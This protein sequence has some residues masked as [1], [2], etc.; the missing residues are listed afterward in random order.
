M[1]TQKYQGRHRP[2]T[3]SAP[4]ET[5]I[6]PPAA[7]IAE[8]ARPVQP[9]QPAHGRHRA[10]AG[11]TVPRLAGT[12]L[13]LPTAAAAAL[14][15][16]TTG[17]HLGSTSGELSRSSVQAQTAASLTDQRTQDLQASALAA[18]ARDTQ[19]ADRDLQRA[20]VG[21]LARESA[22]QAAN[23]KVR[24]T[25]AAAAQAAVAAVAAKASQAA[26][27]HAW[28]PYVTSP[29]TLTSGFGMRWG[30]LHPGQDFAM[31]VGTPL[32]A[33]SSGTVLLAGWSGGYGNKLEIQ[34]WDGTVVWMAHNSVLKVKQGD[35]VTPGEVIA[36]S[37]NTGHST[38][39]HSHLEVHPNGLPTAVPP[40][41]WLTAKGIMPTNAGASA[42][43]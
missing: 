30:S 18:Q 22:Q 20:Q 13:I 42:G 21:V 8:A 5:P 28:V 25:A 11:P 17:A 24:A 12:G 29:F 4:P 41:P 1:L 33:M 32:K 6:S 10:P 43:S 35:A 34:Y 31:A 23:D 39:P 36:L 26:A 14:A 40:I 16:T 3:L 7:A 19:R 38:G 27:L 9:V 15:L 37:G 2:Q